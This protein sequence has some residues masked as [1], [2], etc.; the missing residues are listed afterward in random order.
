MS[1]GGASLSIMKEIIACGLVLCAAPLRAQTNVN[2]NAD[3]YS[4]LK[5]AVADA[6]AP[7][8]PPSAAL[9]APAA[10]AGV[11][12][13]EVVTDPSAFA[14]TAE[15]IASAHDA[16]PAPGTPLDA[17]LAAIMRRVYVSAPA[18]AAVPSAPA[19]LRVI[20]WNTNAPQG[21]DIETV[22]SVLAGDEK[23]LGRSDAK[24][25]G[26]LAATS[27]AD[28]Y[29]IQ[30]MGL[31]A[32]IATAER[33]GLYLAW[34]PEFIEVGVNAEGRDPQSGADMTGN[35]ILSRFPL[36][37]VRTLR[38][39][40]QADWYA[41]EKKGT[42][43]LEKGK[44]EAGRKFFGAEAR[45]HETRPPYGG[46]VALFARV[47]VP[48]RTAAASGA[49]IEAVDLHL[50]SK[51]KPE[52]RRKQMAEVIAAVRGSAEPVV[53]GGD[54]NTMGGDG[55]QLTFGRLLLGQVDT[56]GNAIK[57]GI[58]VGLNFSPVS[59]PSWAYDGY[60]TYAW[61]KS[62]EDPTSVLN[63]EHRLFGDLRSELG[64]RPTN[65]RDTIGYKHTWSTDSPK[66]VTARVLD[67]LFVY[68]PS[69]ALA[70]SDSKTYEKLVDGGNAKHG[71]RFSD[72]FPVRAEIPLRA[73]P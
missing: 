23:V 47:A 48:Y 58:S 51:A 20:T 45:Y 72:H 11:I 69:G 37:D 71:E 25:R 8:E 16:L 43:I 35:A 44:R 39:A 10:R 52:L 36:S 59:E 29:L 3:A 53:F 68:D 49:S 65:Q 12:S 5:A 63:P 9:P 1:R 64:V 55:R 7:A 18:G 67:W 46:R 33:L 57:T 24:I 42:P 38:Y 6:A 56:P 14:L 4:G 70:I 2:W 50:E 60:K 17:K 66:Q 30:E 40:A 34:T 19:V 62:K 27:E 73:R 31:P 22:G 28:V 41:D 32:A 54:L 21:K 26:E 13:P 15:D 61:F